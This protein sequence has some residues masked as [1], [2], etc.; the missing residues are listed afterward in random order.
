[1][2]VEVIDDGEGF[3][4][5]ARDRDRTEVGG[6][7][8]HMVETLSNR[9]GV[10]EARRTSGSSSAAEQ[11]HTP[12][13]WT[14][15]VT[16]SPTRCCPAARPMRSSDGRQIGTVR[17]VQD[18]ARENIFDGIVIDTRRRASASSTRP[19]SPASPSAGSR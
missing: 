6:W 17:R 1:M 11:L 13:S 8:L 12:S 16:R 7:G 19:R 3:V 18:N 14:T 4:P 5:V 10:H 15:T 2:R 9:W